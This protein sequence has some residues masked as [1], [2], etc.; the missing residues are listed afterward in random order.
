MDSGP[1]GTSSKKLERLLGRQSRAKFA[2]RAAAMLVGRK[3]SHVEK[4][5]L[6]RLE[7]D[8]IS[9]ILPRS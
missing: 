1:P 8:R 2:A 5:G 6:W 9:G 7:G 3:S 4:L